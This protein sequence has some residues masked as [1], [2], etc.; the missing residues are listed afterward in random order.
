[1]SDVLPSV[2]ESSS[3]LSDVPPTPAPAPVLQRKRLLAGEQ[4]VSTKRP[5][6]E[7]G[8]NTVE[9]IS[10]P[11]DVSF[12]GDEDE[13]LDSSCSF[14]VGVGDVFDGMDDL[15]E[16][17]ELDEQDEI[18]T[19]DGSD[20][21]PAEDGPDLFDRFSVRKPST[22]LI[23]PKP[24]LSPAS[25]LVSVNGPG[26]AVFQ[27]P[28][29]PCQTEY[30]VLSDLH[31][32]A[33]AHA[34][35]F[36]GLDH[37]RCEFGCA[38]GFVDEF[39]RANHYR[40]GICNVRP[41]KFP[42]EC[43]FPG[44][45]TVGKNESSLFS[46]TKMK[47][48]DI[49]NNEE[50]SKECRDFQIPFDGEPADILRYHF[51][52]GPV[53]HEKSYKRKPRNTADVIRVWQYFIRGMNWPTH[54]NS[55]AS[56]SELSFS[57][58]RT[59][60][61]APFLHRVM[62]DEA[63][64]ITLS[65][66]RKNDTANMSESGEY[67]E[68]GDGQESDVSDTPPNVLNASGDTDA[69]ESASDVSGEI[70]DA[71]HTTGDGVDDDD[72][73]EIQ[74]SQE[75]VYW[76]DADCNYQ[77]MTHG[78]LQRRTASQILSASSSSSAASSSS[79]SAGLGE[80]SALFCCPV[81]G[82]DV[83]DTSLAAS[84]FYKHVEEPIHWEY[85]ASH[86]L[87]CKF[88][89]GRG[90][91][92]EHHRFLHY[93]SGVC[94]SMNKA[95]RPT[96]SRCPPVDI[97]RKEKRPKSCNTTLATSGDAAFAIKHWHSLHGK[98]TYNVDGLFNCTIY[99]IGFDSFGLYKSHLQQQYGRNVDQETSNVH[100]ANMERLGLIWQIDSAHIVSD[101][102][103]QSLPIFNVLRARMFSLS[104]YHATFVF[105]QS[106]SQEGFHTTYAERIVEMAAGMCVGLQDTM[107]ISLDSF[108]VLAG[109]NC[110]G[111]L[112]P[113]FAAHPAAKMRLVQESKQCSGAVTKTD[114]GK[115][116]DICRIVGGATYNITNQLLVGLMNRSRPM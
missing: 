81:C 103:L 109:Q 4:D 13:S 9:N 92:D 22:G 113:S 102:T 28:A 114:S 54:Y 71:T 2:E 82:S 48:A 5:R 46:H 86:G 19:E 112:M 34:D 116:L 110:K 30:H 101:P 59:N 89:C 69:D 93:N 16:L 39:D 25:D 68:N 15:D 111:P 63:L 106:S 24:L 41:S 40:E 1:M 52:S 98:A 17:D 62:K 53:P 90:F 49:H 97:I 18:T 3:P 44:C 32:H 80:Q 94:P 27:C 72:E 43:G 14:G 87:L 33:K 37:Y 36:F 88:D 45:H 56:S 47:H 10:N 38:V 29:P 66:I 6:P 84:R 51:L 76:C 77:H 57:R 74:G 50:L 115:P 64:S 75:K 11:S 107:A 108:A 26:I 61:Q 65:K 60:H 55:R 83:F 95:A 73:D 35:E 7:E 100:A 31:V 70:S 91:L 12:E 96:S 85:L 78:V 67:D 79:S 105:R 8:K 42:K 58:A 23:L 21:I 20:A 99:E 104:G